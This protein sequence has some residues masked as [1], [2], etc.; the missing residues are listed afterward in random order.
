MVVPR[1]SGPSSNCERSLL[2]ARGTGYVHAGEGYW[3]GVD[4]PRRTGDGGEPEPPLPRVVARGRGMRER[5]RPVQPRRRLDAIA[6]LGDM[7]RARACGAASRTLELI[8]DVERRALRAAPPT[9]LG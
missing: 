5:D 2:S 1:R 3:H 7:P 8:C 4:R 6:G 9:G